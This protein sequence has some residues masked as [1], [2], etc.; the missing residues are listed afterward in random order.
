MDYVFGIELSHS[1]PAKII[2]E[3]MLWLPKNIFRT[4]TSGGQFFME[5]FPIPARGLEDE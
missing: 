4:R 3:T 5:A 2:T 1:W